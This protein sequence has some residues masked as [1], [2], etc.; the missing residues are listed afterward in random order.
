MIGERLYE[1]TY[2]ING[3]TETRLEVADTMFEAKLGVKGKLE[4]MGYDV[5]NV[6]FTAKCIG[7]LKGDGYYD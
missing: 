3:V 6:E 7:Y 1:V 2:N 4:E 5:K